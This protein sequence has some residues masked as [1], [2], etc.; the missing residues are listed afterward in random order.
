MKF[1]S[2][3]DNEIE[4]GMATLDEGAN[5][6]LSERKEVKSVTMGGRYAESSWQF[7]CILLSLIRSKSPLQIIRHCGLVIQRAG[8]QPDSIRAIG[9]SLFSSTSE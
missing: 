3:I 7:R 9:P 4:E 1:L 2:L 6:L 5:S 8:V